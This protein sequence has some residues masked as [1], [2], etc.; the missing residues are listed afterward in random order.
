MSDGLNDL[1]QLQ[2]VALDAGLL[3]ALIVDLSA[4]TELLSVIPKATAGYVVPK[5]VPLEEGVKFGAGARFYT[6]SANGMDAGAIV[7][8]LAAKGK[9]IGTPEAFRFDPARRCNH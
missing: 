2:Q 4:L 9:F 5:T 7:D 1:P 6:C 3:D 8:F